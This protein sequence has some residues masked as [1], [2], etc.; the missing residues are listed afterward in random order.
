MTTNENLG[1]A[2]LDVR[3][4]YRLIA[5]YQT[6]MLNLVNDVASNLDVQYYSAHHRYTPPRNYNNP[7]FGL[8]TGVDY[9]PLLDVTYLYLNREAYEQGRINGPQAGDYLIDFRLVSDS[10]LLDEE[11]GREP[12]P[13]EKSAS[14]LITYLFLARESFPQDTNW[15]HKIWDNARY[16]VSDGIW[17]SE[18]N[19]PLAV[20]R[21][22]IQLER[23]VDASQPAMAAAEIRNALTSGQHLVAD[24]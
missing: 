18:G 1:A 13:P 15:Y 8:R 9:L 19:M 11:Q 5:D 12:S 7:P 2:L 24:H 21:I 6:S 16:P 3:K 23:F 10:K 14:L 22:P 4:A 20:C 17:E